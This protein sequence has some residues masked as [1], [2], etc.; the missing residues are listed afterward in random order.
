MN[1]NKYQ[2]ID[3]LNTRLQE[4]RKTEHEKIT[5][6]LEIE[7]TYESNR[8]EGNTLTL[9]ETAL[10]IEKG[11]T[12]GGKTL[13]EYLEAINHTHAIS[14]IKSLAKEKNQITE[15]DILQIHSL[16]LQGINKENAGAYRKVQV[17][18]SGAK[19]IPP[20]PFLVPKKMEELMIWY[21]ENK[22]LL[23][24][25]DLSAEMHERLV[26]IHPF[27]DGN[28]RTSRL[29]MNLILL[30]HGYPIVILKGDVE[31]RLKYYQALELAQVEGDKSTFIRLIED[32]VRMSIERI[33]QIFEN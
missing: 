3:L 33:L 2:E 6:A 23:H 1:Q 8:I 13:N 4:Y 24:P 20:Q 28:G 16:I 11:L 27:I 26:T 7:Y 19:H 29:L 30:Q 18:I 25:I 9:Q 32:N 14:F 17:I 21:N 12:I 10:V 22:N 15:R 31:N 5:Q